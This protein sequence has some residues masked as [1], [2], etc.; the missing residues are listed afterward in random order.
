MRLRRS[1]RL[2]LGHRLR[3]PTGHRSTTRPALTTSRRRADLAR[4]G[5][6]ICKVIVDVPVAPPTGRLTRMVIDDRHP[7]S[8]DARTT[9]ISPNLVRVIFL[10]AKTA[11]NQVFLTWM[12]FDRMRRHMSSQS[13]A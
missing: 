13:L 7:A 2:R 12:I 4:V 8:Y 6:E 1:G 5:D 3:A 9:A 10:E 11:S